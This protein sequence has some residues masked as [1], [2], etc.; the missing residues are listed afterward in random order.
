MA[1]ETNDKTFD[2]KA[3]DKAIKDLVKTYKK[4]GQVTYDVLSDKIA[5]PFSLTA[6]K[7][8]QLLEKV[9]DAGI[10]VVDE[11][12]DPDARAVKAAKKVSKA[13]LKDTSAPSGVK[14]ND[15]VRMYLKEIGRVKLLTA[16][17]E[18]A[19]ALR[20]EEGDEE[21]KQELAEANLRLVVSC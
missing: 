12:G 19:L 20:I 2:Q 10:S 1:K 3:F 21:A 15:P 18:V 17:E 8:D 9:E 5:S 6:K 7:M 11:K 13:E 14:I 16:D 4:Q